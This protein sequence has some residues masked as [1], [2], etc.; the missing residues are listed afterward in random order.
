MLKM[1]MSACI[2]ASPEDTWAFLA[3]LDNISSWSEPVRS[4]E[5]KGDRTKGVGTERT[6]RIGDNTVIT[7]RWISWKE[8]ESYTY[9][10][11][12]LPL[13]KSAKN[14]WSLKAENGNTLLT[15]ESEVVLKGGIFGRILEPLMLLIS[16]KMGSDSLSAFKYLVENGQPYEGKHSSL[17]RVSAI[18]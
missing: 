8:G 7:E 10:G 12:D 17:P 6:C 13:V 4:S 18:C 15:T 1:K 11:F 3:D 14:T 16:K 5:C 9:E 2:N